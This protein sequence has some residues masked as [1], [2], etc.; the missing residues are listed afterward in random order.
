MVHT[1]L[2]WGVPQSFA[3]KS[4]GGWQGLAREVRTARD[5]L[6][7]STGSQAFIL[8]ADK[9]NIAAEMGFYLGTPADIVNDYALG[10]GGLGYRYWVDLKN[11]EGRPAI[12]IFEQDKLGPY[13][14]VWLKQHF[15]KVGELVPVEIRGSGYQKR[16]V[17]LVQCQG[18]IITR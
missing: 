14:V 7:R 9:Y 6:S 12:A 4:S 8:G 16:R 17:Y 2:A 13:S 3:L 5:E 1:S 15:A 10:T 11:L 18:Y